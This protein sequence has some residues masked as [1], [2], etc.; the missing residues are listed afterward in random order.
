MPC[1][2]CR[3]AKDAPSGEEV[4]VVDAEAGGGE[5][6]GEAGGEF[7]EEELGEVEFAEKY[8]TSWMQLYLTGHEEFDSAGL[9]R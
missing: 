2:C 7:V 1:I 6:G 5:A 9:L 4:P 3:M 8:G